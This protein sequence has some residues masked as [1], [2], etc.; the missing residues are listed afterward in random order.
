MS[1]AAP[2]SALQRDILNNPER[3]QGLLPGSQG[4]N[5][6]LTVLCVPHSLDSGGAPRRGRCIG[7]RGLEVELEHDQQ[8][9]QIAFSVPLICTGWRWISTTCGTNQGSEN[10]DLLHI[11]GLVC[12]GNLNAAGDRESWIGNRHLVVPRHLPRHLHPGSYLSSFRQPSR[13]DQTAFKVISGRFQGGLEVP[14]LKAAGA[15]GVGRAAEGVEFEHDQQVKQIA[16][17][18]PLI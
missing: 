4:R 18:V 15:L 3:F 13:Y 5:L 12:G 17:S 16:F 7:Q 11:R 10:D 1:P 14:F 9:E 2:H 6:A 8:V